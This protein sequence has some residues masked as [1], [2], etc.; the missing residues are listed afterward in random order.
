MRHVDPFDPRW[1]KVETAPDGTRVV[2]IDA[3]AIRHE[4]GIDAAIS[5]DT[6]SMCGRPVPV[7]VRSQWD[8]GSQ[9]EYDLSGVCRACQREMFDEPTVCTCATP[10]CEVD[11]GVGIIDCGSQHCPIHGNDES[12][13]ER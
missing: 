9:R 6:C 1:S 12:R 3:E 5:G 11:V 4:L 10:C 8:M 13:A 2:T 7:E